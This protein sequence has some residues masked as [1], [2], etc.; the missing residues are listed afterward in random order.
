MKML[1]VN[2]NYLQIQYLE[3]N[4]VLKLIMMENAQLAILDT[5]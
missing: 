4:N 3:I 1:L 2:N 5:N